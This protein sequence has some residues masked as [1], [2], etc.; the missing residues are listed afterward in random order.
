[1][2]NPTKGQILADKYDI[3]LLLFMGGVMGYANFLSV[4]SLVMIGIG[5]LLFIAVWSEVIQYDDDETSDAIKKE[6]GRARYNKAAIYKYLVAKNLVDLDIVQK[7]D[8][9]E[10]M[11]PVEVA[12]LKQKEK[13]TQ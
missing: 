3:P 1:M 10:V 7:L 13:G 11:T 6:R 5:I 12:E 9:W 4:L 8:L 2:A